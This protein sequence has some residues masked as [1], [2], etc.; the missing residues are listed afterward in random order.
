MTNTDL[1]PVSAPTDSAP[2]ESAPSDSA[3][4]DDQRPDPA[5]PE[6]AAFRTEAT[7]LAE[8]RPETGEPTA[9]AAP[10]QRA[11]RPAPAPRKTGSTLLG[12]VIGAVLA[13]G[14]GYYVQRYLVPQPAFDPAPF[15]ARLTAAEAE[16]QALRAEIARLSDAP[17]PDPAAD[18]AAD[19]ALAD[20]IAT[21]EAVPP[22]DMAA[23]SARLDALDGRLAAL[24]D[25]PSAT[26]VSPA[27]LAALQAEIAA[28]KSQ[29]SGASA[30]L[31][32]LAAEVEARLTEA[33]ARAADLTTQATAIAA[34]ATRNAAL[35]QI[36][37]AL[38]SGLPYRAAL[39]AL[40][41]APLPEVIA[42]HADTGQP[43]LATLRAAFPD[44]ARLALEQALR[45]NP[46]ESWTDRVG[47]FLRN[48]TGA[49]S[50]APRDGADPDAILSRAEAALNGAD[51][52]A[53]LTELAALPPEAQ[54]AMADWVALATQRVAA[55]AALAGLLQG[56][57]Q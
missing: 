50:L 8:P 30:D 36:G 45:A 18:S 29:G 37:A 53:T 55:Q 33:Q 57:G 2:T 52:P 11:T 25:T 46:G 51:L 31:T 27:A 7:V 56:T 39:S 54:A 4:S 5:L 15:E 19:S 43:S 48:Q 14:G 22:P 17:A 24:A 6:P 35:A 3:P 23:L 1:R 41:D 12:I 10:V 20:R 21:L 26:G 42:T 9:P 13:V 47:S 32:N 40:G 44:A 49:R 16:A 38:D 28:L 34:A